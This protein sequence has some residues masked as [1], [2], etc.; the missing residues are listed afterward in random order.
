MINYLEDIWLTMLS[1]SS[2]NAVIWSGKRASYRYICNCVRVFCRSFD[3]FQLQLG[4]RVVIQAQNE[5]L[6][7]AAFMAALLDGLVPVMVSPDAG[8]KR[9][10]AIIQNVDARVVIDDSFPLDETSGGFFEWFRGSSKAGRDP[11]VPKCITTEIAY[12]LFTSGSTAAPRGVQISYLNL[13]A[14]LNTVQRLF[15]FD[16]KSRIVN[17]T[18]LSHTDGLIQGPVLTFSV[19]ATLL[20]PGRFEISSLESWLDF[21]RSSEPTH[22]IANPTLLSILSRLAPDEDWIVPRKFFGVISTG[23]VLAES[24]WDQFERKFGVSVFNVYGMTETVADALFAGNHP[25]MGARGTIGIPVDCEADIMGHSDEGELLLRGN[26]I[27]SGYW[28]NPYLTAETRTADGWFKTGDLVRRLDSGSFEYIGRLNSTINQGSV[29]IHPEEI[30]EILMLHPYVLEAVTFSIPDDEFEEIAVSAVTVAQVVEQGELYELCFKHL[31]SLK[32]PKQI[33]VVESIP[34]TDAGK[35]DR[36]ALA[37]IVLNKDS[38]LARVSEQ[39]LTAQILQLI[40]RVFDLPLE[41]LSPSLLASEIAAWDSFNHLK[42]IL[43]VE[44]AFKISFETRE[45]I[46]I[47]SIESLINSVS[48]HIASNSL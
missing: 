8:Q 43:E 29:R 21:V 32:C 2:R 28:G 47:R 6:A 9:I 45:I 12:I 17:A 24:L 18:P 39:N 15:C 41:D 38:C 46:N 5:G 14:Q 7:S 48:V 27:S 30:D 22:M 35:V 23:G 26:N 25:E 34:R 16:K 11:A 40:A 13:F 31:E 1:Q 33:G 44:S 10:N 20:R 19:G 37:R 3:D 36:K 4:E 42:L